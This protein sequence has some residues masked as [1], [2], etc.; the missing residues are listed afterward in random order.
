MPAPVPVDS[1]IGVPSR[2]LAR[3]IRSATTLANG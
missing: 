2:G 3:A 1:M